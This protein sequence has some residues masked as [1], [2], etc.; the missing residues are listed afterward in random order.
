MLINFKIITRVIFSVVFLISIF[1]NVNS[2]FSMSLN[3]IFRYI[4][5]IYLSVNVEYGKNTDELVKIKPELKDLL[6]EY[7]KRNLETV[8][9]VESRDI[10]DLSKYLSRGPLEVSLEVLICCELENKIF[11]AAQLRFFRL[12]KHGE[13]FKSDT[14]GGLRLIG[15]HVSLAD[16]N[17]GARIFRKLIP[18]LYEGVVQPIKTLKPFD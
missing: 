7:I 2:S 1:F 5:T 6:A 11:V 12:R 9:L 13:K 17:V 10:P 14:W 16:N 4:D 3:G 18:Y 15:F 8:E